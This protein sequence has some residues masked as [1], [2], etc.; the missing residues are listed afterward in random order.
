M[1]SR[2]EKRFS[3]VALL[4]P[5][6]DLRKGAPCVKFAKIVAIGLV[7]SANDGCISVVIDGGTTVARTV[8]TRYFLDLTFRDSIYLVGSTANDA[9]QQFAEYTVSEWTGS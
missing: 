1:I 5:Y 9:D 4:R 8:A 2:S 7:V 3:P 6:D